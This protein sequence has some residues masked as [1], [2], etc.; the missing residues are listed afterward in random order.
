MKASCV[1]VL[2]SCAKS[3]LGVAAVSSLLIAQASAQGEALATDPTVI[4]RASHPQVRINLPSPVREENKPQATQQ[5]H[6]GV[7]GAITLAGTRLALADAVAALQ[8]Q[9]SAEPTLT[10]VTAAGELPIEEIVELLTA[11]TQAQD[12]DL[13]VTELEDFRTFGGNDRDGQPVDAGNAFRGIVRRYELPVFVAFSPEDGCTASLHG[14][15]RSSSGLF[16]SGF[17]ALDQWVQNAGGVEA[18][19]SDPDII[20][21]IVATI[22]ARPDTPWRCIAGATFSVQ[23]AGYPSVRYEVVDGD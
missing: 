9:A 7:D 21:A 8:P 14:R 6:L 20:G 22:Q 3:V 5:L 13:T 23:A 2:R 19:L 10:Q 17:S 12:A 4:D 11:L 18:V 16:D 15:M 1:Q